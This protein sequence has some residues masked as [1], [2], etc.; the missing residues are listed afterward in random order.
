MVQLSDGAA[1][2]AVVAACALVTAATV[3]MQVTVFFIENSSMV[4]LGKRS[5]PAIVPT[6]RFAEL[7]RAIPRT[8]LFHWKDGELHGEELLLTTPFS[9]TKPLVCSGAHCRSDIKRYLRLS[10]AVRQLRVG[11]IIFRELC[12]LKTINTRDAAAEWNWLYCPAVATSATG[13]ALIATVRIRLRIGKLKRIY[14]HCSP[15]GSGSR[16]RYSLYCASA[17]PV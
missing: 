16:Y 11:S 9:F 1:D 17:W 12:S 13:N 15:Q 2:I 6:S 3:A 5:T 8:A 7:G 10:V 4:V 14:G